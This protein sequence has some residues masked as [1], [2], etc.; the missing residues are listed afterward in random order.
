MKKIIS[1]IIIVLIIAFIWSNSFQNST[2]SYKFSM[3]FTKNIQFLL[4]KLDLDP[5]LNNMGVFV[6]KLAHLT[7][8]MSLGAMIYYTFKQVFKT[9]IVL[10]SILLAISIASLD[11]VIQI[12]SPGRTATITDVLLDTTGSMIGILIVKGLLKLIH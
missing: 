10:K 7:E 1:F 4:I 3:F 2:D 11:E 12:Y 5:N 6:R 9:H 8:F